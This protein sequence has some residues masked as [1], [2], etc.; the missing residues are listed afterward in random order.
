[1]VGEG[2]R[3]DLGYVGSRSRSQHEVLDC[4]WGQGASTGG[5][6]QVWLD[7]YLQ[8]WIDRLLGLKCRET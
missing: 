2:A 6:G 1:M 5:A 3:R 7:S 4:V 8:L